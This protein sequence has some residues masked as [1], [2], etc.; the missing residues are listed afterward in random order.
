MFERSI[1][2][3]RDRQLGRLEGYLA[4]ALFGRGQIALAVG[5]AGSGKTSLIREFARSALE[6][7]PELLIA[8][9]ESNSQ[10]GIGD[11]Y[12]PFREILTSLSRNLHGGRAST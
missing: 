9:G 2:V 4:E 5:D 12:L 10:T 1:L 8:A 6:A 7:N 3:A 11:P